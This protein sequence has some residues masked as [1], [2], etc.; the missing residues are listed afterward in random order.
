MLSS[1]ALLLN[2]S[3][4]GFPLICGDG[5]SVFIL[6][7]AL[8]MSSTVTLAL[9]KRRKWKCRIVLYTSDRRGRT[10]FPLYL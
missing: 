4:L 3:D 2:P 8:C 1:V 7:L 5:L 10:V 6:S 9:D